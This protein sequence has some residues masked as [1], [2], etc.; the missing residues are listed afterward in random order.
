MHGLLTE[1][2]IPYRRVSARVVYTV[3]GIERRADVRLLTPKGKR[4]DQMPVIWYDPADPARVTGFGPG[5]T[6]PFFGLSAVMALLA[7]CWST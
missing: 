5:A 4:A 7:Y 6:L 3:G 1:E 2:D